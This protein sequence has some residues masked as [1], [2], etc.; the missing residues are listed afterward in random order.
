MKKKT[1]KIKDWLKE[2]EAQFEPLIWDGE[3]K[4]LRILTAK[5]FFD[6]VV[7][8]RGVEYNFEYLSKEYPIKIISFCKDYVHVI[9]GIVKDE[10]KGRVTAKFCQINDLR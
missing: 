8:E 9:Y 5:R 7:F 10:E 1:L 4:K 2:I 6:E 3:E